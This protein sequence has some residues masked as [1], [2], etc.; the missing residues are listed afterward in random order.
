MRISHI[1]IRTEDDPDVTPY[2]HEKQIEI[3]KCD[4]AIIPFPQ[5]IK[6]EINNLLSKPLRDFSSN[7]LIFSTQPSNFNRFVLNQVE[8]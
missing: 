5:Q 1:E 7:K 3:I 8:E 2:V 6:E 4:E